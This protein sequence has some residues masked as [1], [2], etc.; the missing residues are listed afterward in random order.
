MPTYTFRRAD[1]A[2][3]TRKLSF[4]EYGL[5]KSGDFQV[6]DDE[7]QTLELVF[8]PTGVG[9]VL[10]DGPSGGWTSKANKENGYR[11]GRGAVMARREKD[12]VFKTR[13]I[14]NYRGEEASNWKEVREEVRRVGGDA[15]AAT[16]DHH[17]SKEGA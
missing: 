6:V 4:E 11:Q 7:G 14:P 3:S 5:V 13:L 17:V 1:G 2:T 10:K 9:F 15:K 12:H 16:Y 8:N